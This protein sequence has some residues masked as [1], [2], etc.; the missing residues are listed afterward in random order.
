MTF[1]ILRELVFRRVVA[2]AAAEE[3]AP[4]RVRMDFFEVWCSSHTSVLSGSTRH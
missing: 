1:R 3:V 2:R 4:K